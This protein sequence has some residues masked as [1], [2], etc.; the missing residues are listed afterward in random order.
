MHKLLL[1]AV[2]A[3]VVIATPL[4]FAQH[5][6]TFDVPGADG[7][8]P[9]FISHDGKIVGLS[10]AGS[11]TC[12]FLRNPDGTFVVLHPTGAMT[13]FGIAVNDAG[14][15]LGGYLDSSFVNHG[16]LWNPDGTYT[17]IDIGSVSTAPTAMNRAGDIVG[18]NGTQSFLRK[19]DGTVTLFSLG[20]QTYAGAI[21]SADQ[22]VGTYT[23]EAFKTHA[24]LRN[25]DGSVISFDL[26]EGGTFPVGINSKGVVTG[27]S[28]YGKQPLGR[29]FL[30]KTDGTFVF[31]AHD[32]SESNVPASINSAGTVVGLWGSDFGNGE[33]FVLAANG[34]A[35]TLDVPG[36][37]FTSLR[38]INDLGAIV[39]QYTDTLAT[40][41]FIATK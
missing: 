11:V 35:A 38:G 17:N 32:M 5:I 12:G 28:Y 10:L 34:K 14:Q 37:S 13:S 19:A 15:V 22:I 40:H 4:G 29:A 41:G 23:D 27:V 25:T 8:T 20:P 9:V 33:G 7:T 36:A 21:N 30:R 6:T 24:Y 26:G 3:T 39:G 2:L 16:F 18:V 1:V 31:F